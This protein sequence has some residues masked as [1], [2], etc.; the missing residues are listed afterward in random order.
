MNWGKDLFTNLWDGI[1]SVWTNIKDWWNNAWDSVF[2]KE[3][4]INV[5][6]NTSSGGDT[7]AGTERAGVDPTIWGMYQT[8]KEKAEERGYDSDFSFEDYKNAG[9]SA[10]EYKEWKENKN[11]PSVTNITIN[12]PV[13]SPDEVAKA[14]DNSKRYGF[15]GR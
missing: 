11:K 4:E 10:P 14:I 6:G 15:A 7:Y 3:K 1:K 2:G 13:K 8:S 9:Y 5:K 12:Q